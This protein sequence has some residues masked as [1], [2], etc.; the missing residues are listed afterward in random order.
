MQEYEIRIFQEK[1]TPAVVAMEVQLSDTA[2][3]RSARRMARGK[4]FEVW[5]G[6]ECITGLMKPPAS[7][8]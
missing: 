4:P 6:L 3:V 1:G 5:R 2:A 8:S 7:P